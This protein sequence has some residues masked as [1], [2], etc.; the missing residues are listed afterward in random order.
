VVTRQGPVVAEIKSEYVYTNGHVLTVTVIM[1]AADPGVEIHT[2]A[3]GDRL[4]HRYRGKEVRIH[5]PHPRLD[6]VKDMVLSWKDD[7]MRHPYLLM[8]AREFNEAASYN[9]ANFNKSADAKGL[10]KTLDTLGD[11]DL[12]REP[13]HVTFLYDSNIDSDRLT[14]AE[15]EI[16]K[17]QFAYLGYLLHNPA[18]WSFERGMN[19]GNPNMVVSRILSLSMLGLCMRGNPQGAA[20]VEYGKE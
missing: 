16:A 19:S 7:R 20:W 5:S 15:R 17:A 3:S 13:K 6:Q 2:H 10:L 18:H 1:N 11:M 8:R 14:K 12:M 4:I 9:H